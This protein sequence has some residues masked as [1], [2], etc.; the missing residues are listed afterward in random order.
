MTL[1]PTQY[2]T[3]KKN[4][5]IPYKTQNHV[6]TKSALSSIP[7][8]FS[9]SQLNRARFYQKNID[10]ITI[11]HRNLVSFWVFFRITIYKP[12][13]IFQKCMKSDMKYSCDFFLFFFAK[14]PCIKR[15]SKKKTFLAECT[16]DF[17]KIWNFQLILKKNYP[18]YPIRN[19]WFL[20][21]LKK[22]HTVTPIRND[23][24]LANFQEKS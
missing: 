14:S 24:F 7:M 8:Y 19:G 6:L 13:L 9:P 18:I 5:N 2:L 12:I 15:I 17:V 11:L 21:I 16:A 3:P 23:W 4:V 10:E 22:N 20:L 1:G